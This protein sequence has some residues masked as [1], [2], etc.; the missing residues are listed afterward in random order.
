MEKMCT[1]SNPFTL[2][3]SIP[4]EWQ[5]QELPTFVAPKF[6]RPERKS[7]SLVPSPHSK[8]LP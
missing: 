7:G 4:K 5:D 6:L 1:M 8:M 3:F 2:T